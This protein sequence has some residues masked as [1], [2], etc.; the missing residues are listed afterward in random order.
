MRRTLYFYVMS[1]QI[2]MNDYVL[3][4]RYFTT[5]S[6]N[7]I[8]VRFTDLGLDMVSKSSGTR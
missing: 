1:C 6:A 7:Q 3:I 4:I 2:L 5:L 8:V